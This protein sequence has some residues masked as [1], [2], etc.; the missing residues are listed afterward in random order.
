MSIAGLAFHHVGIATRDLDAALRVYESLG[1]ELILRL[2]DEA[3][4]V[5]AAFLETT[6]ATPGAATALPNG[7][8]GP[9]IE[10]VAAMDEAG[11]PLRALL[12][13][14][15]VPGPYHTCY[16]VDDLVAASVKLRERGFVALGK[17]TPA[18]AF[19]GAPILFHMHA[20]IGLVE[21]IERPGF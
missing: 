15:A 11:G 13:R 20:A 19:G 18:K 16:A 2:T 6:A 9:Y 4:G 14:G 12:K 8:S 17:P 5:H 7:C 1:H 10:L 3:L 21:L